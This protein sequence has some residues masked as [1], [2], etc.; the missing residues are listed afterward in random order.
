VQYVDDT[1]LFLP[2]V[3]SQLLYL[4]LFLHQF[5][6]STGLKVNFSKSFLVPINVS[7]DKASSLA[8]SFEC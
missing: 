5:A 4:K 8:A 6:S 7:D 3:E 2:A 1:L